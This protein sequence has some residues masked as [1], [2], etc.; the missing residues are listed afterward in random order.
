MK[1]SLAVETGIV[2]LPV[3][4]RLH[5]AQRVLSVYDGTEA[6]VYVTDGALGQVS[7]Q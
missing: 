7:R 3:Q 5:T 4:V 1:I 6:G 2:N